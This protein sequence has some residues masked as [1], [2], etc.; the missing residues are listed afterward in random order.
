MIL[1]LSL[2]ALFIIV[3]S[4]FFIFLLILLLVLASRYIE[5]G[6]RR[7]GR[8][9]EE[10][11]SDLIRD[12]LNEDDI[13]LN[14]VSILADDKEAE[15]D[16]VIVNK[17]GVFVIEV[18]NY[19]GTLVGEEDDYEWVKKKISSGG[20]LYI[21]NV[22]NPIKQVKRQVY[23]LSRFLKDNKINAWIDGYV[24]LV[25]RN[26]PVESE[27]VL[28]SKSDINEVI[29]R[30]GKKP[31]SEKTVKKICSLLEINDNEEI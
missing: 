22:K 19:S 11:V 10:Y 12:V 6:H 14:N 27:Y 24:F 3:G 31:L 26:S 1:G 25:E 4:T 13:L 20:E 21:K 8:R 18:K 30:P 9:G 28:E 17:N 23:V 7:A 29:H 15:L 16:N 5:P 2:T